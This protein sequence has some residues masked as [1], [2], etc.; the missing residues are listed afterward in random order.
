M[1][2]VNALKICCKKRASVRPVLRIYGVTQE[3]DVRKPFCTLPA[4]KVNAQ[5]FNWIMWN[6]EVDE[7]VT[8][9]LVEQKKQTVFTVRL[10]N[11]KYR[12]LQVQEVKET[13]ELFGKSLYHW[14]NAIVYRCL[15]VKE[16]ENSIK[17][18]DVL[19]DIEN[20]NLLMN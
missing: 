19:N 6:L 3:E 2:L 17:N 18:A 8:I 10:V 4:E 14:N 16:I 7:Y 1:K 15:S 12:G 20:K 13:L 11:N 9:R 5:L